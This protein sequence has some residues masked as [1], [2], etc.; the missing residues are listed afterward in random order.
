MSVYAGHSWPEKGLGEGEPESFAL[1]EGGPSSVGLL[2][3]G[4]GMPGTRQCNTVEQRRHLDREME[5]RARGTKGVRCVFIHGSS[6]L[7]GILDWI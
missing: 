6:M 2:G 5:V 1:R 3:R 7:H 4:P